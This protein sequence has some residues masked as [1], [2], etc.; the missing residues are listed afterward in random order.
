[1]DIIK[2]FKQTLER[3][4]KK[5]DDTRNQQM[6]N[7]WYQSYNPLEKYA[8][9]A[10]N[11]DKLKEELLQGI[12]PAL[13]KPK[14]YLLWWLGAAAAL[15]LVTG[16]AFYNSQNKIQIQQPAL[17]SSVTETGM[18]K[19]LV[20]ADGTEVWLNAS[21]KLNYP[22]SF[23]KQTRK[24]YLPQGEAFFEVKRNV[25]RPFKVIIGKLEVRVLGTSFN[26]NNYADLECQ[27]VVVNT[28]KVQVSEG[29]KV[30]A[31]LEKGNQ[32]LYHKKTRR[33]E[34]KQVDQNLSYSW[35]EAKTVLQ[36]ADFGALAS[37]FKN[38]YG[39]TL[40]SSINEIN[41]FSYT[42]TILRQVSLADNLDLICKM[43]H[44]KYRKEGNMI[45]LY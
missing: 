11:K 34:I 29:N 35:R 28:G 13:N 12:L 27:T 23:E 30:L 20:L 41:Q 42:L 10:I 18:L 2:Q 7:G 33:F 8:F 14:R 17:L 26:L 37:V 45:V 1:M 4:L 16:L 25:A 31:I 43:H 21:S 32:L 15:L 22:I 36:N 39:V 6:V 44:N 24:V 38:L 5:P 9:R 3:F 40:H 19:H